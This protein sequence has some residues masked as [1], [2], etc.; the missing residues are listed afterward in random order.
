MGYLYLRSVCLRLI[1]NT[2]QR[3]WL[4]VR[5]LLACGIRISVRVSEH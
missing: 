4:L 1:G 3:G 5:G 2:E